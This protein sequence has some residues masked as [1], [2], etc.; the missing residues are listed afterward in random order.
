[1][2]KE[3]GT[4]EQTNTDTLDPYDLF[5]RGLKRSTKWKPNAYQFIKSKHRYKKE[6][7]EETP[8]IRQK[9]SFIGNIANR[10]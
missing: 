5:L 4:N 2:Q 9:F 3:T 10:D 7:D 6:E 8:G 1:M